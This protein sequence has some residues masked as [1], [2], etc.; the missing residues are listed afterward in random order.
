V[1]IDQRLQHLALGPRKTIEHG[2]SQRWTRTWR[3]WLRRARAALISKPHGPAGRV[4]DKPLRSQLAACVVEGSSAGTV[5][6]EKGDRLDRRFLDALGAA[7]KWKASANELTLLDAN[8]HPV[9]TFEARL[10]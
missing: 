4:L 1:R 10:P 9:A 5:V 8:E 7:K 6:S 3:L 2:R